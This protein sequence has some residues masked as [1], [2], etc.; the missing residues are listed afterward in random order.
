MSS[1]PRLQS[2]PNASRRWQCSD[3]ASVCADRGYYSRDFVA[4]VWALCFVHLVAKDEHEWRSEIDQSTARHPGVR[5][6]QRPRKP[7]EV[8]FCWLNPA[9]AGGKMPYRGRPSTSSG[10]N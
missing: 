7:F 8:A 5:Q 6:S 1:R 2:L 9:G 10:S 4:D 3:T